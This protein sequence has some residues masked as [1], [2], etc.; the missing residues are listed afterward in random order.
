LEASFVQADHSVH[1]RGEALVVR[2]DEGGTAF[3]A[4]QVQEFAED[5]VRGVLVEIAS[6]LVGEEDGGLVDDGSGDGDALLLSA[7]QLRWTVV[8]PVGKAERA[9]QLLRTVAGS[10][11]VRAVDQLR[12]NDI[13][14]RVEVGQ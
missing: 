14:D 5:R 12:K 4:D 8:E 1:F 13:L 6:G 11:R 10:L 9:K 3:A 2:G 7:G